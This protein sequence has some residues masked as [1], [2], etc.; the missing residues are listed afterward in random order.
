MTV[1]R[2]I[3]D[4]STDPG[5]KSGSEWTSD[6]RESVLELWKLLGGMVGSI[7][8]TNAI[9]GTVLVSNGFTSYSD[10]QLFVWIPANTN[11]GACTADWGPGVKPLRD[12]N[13]DALT[14]GAVVAG[15]LTAAV[16]CADDDHFRLL[17]S[18]GTTN[19]TVTG[20]IMLKLSDPSRLA[21]AVSATTSTTSVASRAFQTTYS[22][23]RVIVEGNVSLVTNS[24]TASATG[25]TVALYVD[26]VEVETFTDSCQSAQKH[27]VPFHFSYLPTDTDSHTYEV[28][29]T[30]SIAATYPKD[31]NWLVCSEVS[32][33]V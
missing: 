4:I 11:T 20:G 7:A 27:S 15:R 19:V 3:G 29:V 13:G 23:S 33:N 12:N 9:T 17:T 30:S 14:A 25:I 1:S 24:G 8:G 5:G 16:F 18:G 31:A 22:D 28:R 21:A 10:G 6:T 32:P 26:T 2:D